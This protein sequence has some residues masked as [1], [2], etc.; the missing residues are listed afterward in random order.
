VHQGKLWR[1][2]KRKQ[3]EVVPS[4]RKSLRGYEGKGLKDNEVEEGRLGEELAQLQLVNWDKARKST[5]LGAGRRPV[6]NPL[7]A[8]KGIPFLLAAP[9]KLPNPVSIVGRGGV[10]SS[11]AALRP[12]ALLG[13]VATAVAAPTLPLMVVL[14]TMMM[15]KMML[16]LRRFATRNV[17]GVVMRRFIIHVKHTVSLRRGTSWETCPN[18]AP[19]SERDVGDLD[20]RAASGIGAPAFAQKRPL[21][22]VTSL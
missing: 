5:P 19:S 22:D 20:R 11:V 17:K 8:P 2:E 9:V 4:R 10:G 18:L 15:I 12:R 21:V 16:I 3:N 13:T 14:R 6:T 1:F 7:E